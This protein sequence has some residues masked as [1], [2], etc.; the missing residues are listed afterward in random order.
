VAA[1]AQSGEHRSG[2]Q[3]RRTYGHSLVVDPWGRVLAELHES[4]RIHTQELDKSAIEKVRRQIPM[5]SHR[6]L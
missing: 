4:P 1:P 5:D 3:V 2:D 6:R